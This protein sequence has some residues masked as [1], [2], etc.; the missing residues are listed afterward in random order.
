ASLFSYASEM[1]TEAAEVVA[2]EKVI[3]L[4]WWLKLSLLGAA[5]AI[6]LM[7]WMEFPKQNAVA[8]AAPDEFVAQLTGAK[9]CQ[10]VGSNSIVQ[11]GGRFRKGQKLE[12]A[13]GFAEITF[14]SGA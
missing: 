13:K 7:L 10:W 8:A 2:Q 12:L 9:E 4:D 3:H 5:A 1:Q 11:P 6:A 14:D